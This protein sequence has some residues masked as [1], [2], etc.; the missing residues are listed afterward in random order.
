MKFNQLF[1]DSRYLATWCDKMLP[2][3]YSGGDDD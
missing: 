1:E 3:N 2:N